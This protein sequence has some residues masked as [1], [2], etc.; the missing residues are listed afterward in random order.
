VQPYLEELRSQGKS[1][2]IMMI[3]TPKTLRDANV[4]PEQYQL[5]QETGVYDLVRVPLR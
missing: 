1:S 4:K 3:T 2:S 5:I